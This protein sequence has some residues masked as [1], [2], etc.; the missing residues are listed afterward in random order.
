MFASKSYRNCLEAEQLL[1]KDIRSEQVA[2]RDRAMSANALVRVLEQKRIMK[3]KPAP[4]PVDAKQ[5][6]EEKKRRG[7]CGASS[8][9]PIELP[10][11]EAEEPPAKPKSL[12]A[13]M[14][15]EPIV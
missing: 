1:M 11:T 9:E 5:Y 8:T 14:K 10:L 3:M 7:A 4:K 15:G 2:A 13:R 6:E 12:K